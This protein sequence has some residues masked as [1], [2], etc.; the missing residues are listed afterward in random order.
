PEPFMSLLGFTYQTVALTMLSAACWGAA[1]YGVSIQLPR[2][3]LLR[4]YEHWKVG[5]VTLPMS[6]VL[7]ATMVLGAFIVQRTTIVWTLRLGL[8][9]M[10]AL[11]F[12]LSRVDLY[13]SWQ[14]LM[15]VTCAWA[16]CAGI[17]LPAIARLVYEGQPPEQAATTGAMKFFVRSFGGTVGI[18]LA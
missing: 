1:M 10:T 4:G 2:Y 5:W 14:W 3:L 12:W 9:G 6:L 17:C 18:L 16:F 8:A 11:G 15:A 7:V 13:T